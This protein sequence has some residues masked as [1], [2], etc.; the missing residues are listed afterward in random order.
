MVGAVPLPV[1]LRGLARV[2]RRLRE[3]RGY[4]QDRFAVVIGVHRTYMGHLERGTVNPTLRTLDLVA[5]G[6]DLSIPELLTLAAKEGNEGPIARRYTPIRRVADPSAGKP[7][8]AKR[9]K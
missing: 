8:M 6:L 5:R 9:G 7:G 4:S 1:L 3:R 2:I